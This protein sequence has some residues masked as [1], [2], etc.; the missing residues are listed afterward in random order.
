[1]N[2]GC[3]R[4]QIEDREQAEKGT[5]VYDGDKLMPCILLFDS[6]L[7]LHKTEEITNNINK[8]LWMIWQ[9]EFDPSKEKKFKHFELLVREPKGKSW[10][11]SV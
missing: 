10:A 11:F 9:R 7:G 3:I 1:M 6:L 5:A 8:W 2:P 4:Q